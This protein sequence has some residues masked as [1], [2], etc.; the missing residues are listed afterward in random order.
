MSNVKI[1]VSI[2]ELFDKYTI[3]QIKKRHIQDE[4]KLKFIDNEIQYLKNIKDSL[5]VPIKLVQK[6]EVVN[7][8]L[9][10]I[11]DTLRIK[12]SKN[13]FDG[14]FISLARSVY[15]TN[16]IRN[17]IK[18]TISNLFNSDILDVKSYQTSP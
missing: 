12:E 17:D 15:K 18:N 6:L 1:N 5:F 13:E 3:L 9:W 8:N 16:D 4:T 2:G 14:E 10:N 7:N 11:Q